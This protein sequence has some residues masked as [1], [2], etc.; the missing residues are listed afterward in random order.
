MFSLL[1][2][3]DGTLEGKEK[4]KKKNASVRVP[5]YKPPR[6]MGSISVMATAIGNQES[7]LRDKESR[8]EGRYTLILSKNGL[9]STKC[10]KC[11]AQR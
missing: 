5:M 6:E 4:K 7:S 1:E 9:S 8:I 10:A 11:T 2:R 3:P